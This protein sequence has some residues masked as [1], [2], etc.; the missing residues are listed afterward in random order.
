MIWTVVWFALGMVALFF[1]GWIKSH[2]KTL[3]AYWAT[4]R[5]DQRVVARAM[6]TYVVSCASV[7]AL[8]GALTWSSILLGVVCKDY[9]T[10]AQKQKDDPHK[11]KG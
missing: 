2:D 4:L 1:D 10:T 9:L 7:Y 6:L 8:D 3:R 5:S 11:L